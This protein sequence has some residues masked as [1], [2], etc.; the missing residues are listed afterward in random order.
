M[1]QIENQNINMFTYLK[2]GFLYSPTD[3]YNRAFL[4]LFNQMRQS[5]VCCH[6]KSFYRV[7]Q[8]QIEQF[9]QAM[10]MPSNSETPYFSLTF[11]SE[12]THYHLA[13]PVILLSLISYAIESINPAFHYWTAYNRSRSVCDN[14]WV[15]RILSA[16]CFQPIWSGPALP[17]LS[18]PFL[19]LSFENTLHSLH[20]FKVLF[21]TKIKNFHLFLR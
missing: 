17:L 4:L 11:L 19:V 10:N 21:F 20:L 1:F 14:F 16:N 12:M 8:A 15:Q 5:K 6:K 18:G 2:D 13:V 7:Y 3:T 9:V